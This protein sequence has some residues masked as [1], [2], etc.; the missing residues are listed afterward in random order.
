MEEQL[1]VEWSRNGHGKEKDRVEGVHGEGKDGE[2]VVDE[3]GVDG[4]ECED[5]AEV[6]AAARGVGKGIVA[7]NDAET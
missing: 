6:A 5:G 4:E 2:D 1:E 7:W 3:E